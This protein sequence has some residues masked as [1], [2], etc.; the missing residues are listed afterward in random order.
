MK[1]RRLEC[2]DWPAGGGKE[3]K[4]KDPKH[5]WHSYTQLKSKMDLLFK[6]RNYYYLVNMNFQMG[7]CLI[8][9]H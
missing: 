7:K 2:W 6:E 1:G 3:G 4:G 8:F 9:A 5:R